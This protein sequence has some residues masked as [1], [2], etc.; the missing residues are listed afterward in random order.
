MG[1]R[2]NSIC[3]DIVSNQHMSDR[4]CSETLKGYSHEACDIALKGRSLAMMALA[5][6]FM[7]KSTTCLVLHL[8]FI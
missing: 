8:R 4:N 1:V 5:D 6:D 7:R 2:E 3:P